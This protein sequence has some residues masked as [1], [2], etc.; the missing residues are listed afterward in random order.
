MVFQGAAVGIVLGDS[1]CRAQTNA[2]AAAPV[3]LPPITVNGAATESRPGWLQEEQYLGPYQQPEWTTERRFPGTRV[4]LQQMPWDMGF[5]QWARYRHFRDGT[6]ETRFQE[7]Y[8]IG[9]PYRFQVDLYETWATDE[10]HRTQQD[11]MSAEV[12]Y[13]LADWGKIPLNPTLYLE[14]AEHDHDA[15]TLEGKVLLGTDLTHRLHWGLNFACEQ[16]L[17]QPNNTELAVSQGVSYSLVEERL[18]VGMEME[19]YHEKAA[20]SAPQNEFLIGPSLQWRPAPWCHVDLAP[21]FGCTHDAPQI[22]AFLVI[23]F[24]FDTGHHRAEHY[25][26]ASLRGQ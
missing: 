25:A 24:D 18:G 2:V 10:H 7:E 13:A 8:E 6:A 14:Y 12:R 22:E 4:Y 9:L 19:Y 3:T 16:E 11:E 1:L 21:L 26:P 23:G 20:G 5:E 17:G 15:N